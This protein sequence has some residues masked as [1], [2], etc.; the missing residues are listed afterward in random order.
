MRKGRERK[1]KGK[2]KHGGEKEKKGIEIIRKIQKEIRR[3]IL[4]TAHQSF[5]RSF[6]Y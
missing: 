5:T 1:E 3:Y 2:M 4:S 6:F